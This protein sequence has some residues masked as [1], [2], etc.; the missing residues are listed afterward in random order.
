MRAIKFVCTYFFYISVT[1][2]P[3]QAFCRSTFQN[4]QNKYL[5]SCKLEWK[6]L[7]TIENTVIVI[8]VRTSRL[9]DDITETLNSFKITGQPKIMLIVMHYCERDIEPENLL[10]ENRDSRVSSFAN[11][12]YSDSE[13]C[14]DCH[15]NSKAVKAIKDFIR[16]N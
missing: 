9:E 11:I 10:T 7:Q 15:I 3:S 16:S 12:V 6:D 1:T 4:F 13:Q 8:C 5:P 14:Y 2:S